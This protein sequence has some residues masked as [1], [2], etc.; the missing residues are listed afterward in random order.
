MKLSLL[1]MLGFSMVSIALAGCTLVEQNPVSEEQSIS[2]FKPNSTAIPFGKALRRKWGGAVVA[3]LDQDGW[4]DVITTHHGIHAQIYWNNQGKFSEPES[5]VKGDTHGLGVSD[6][7]G[8]GLI[9]IIVAQGGGDGS[10]PR[11]PLHFSVDRNRKVT[12]VGVF[13]YFTASRG[14]SIKYLDAD[15]DSV[16][17]LFV[18]GFAPRQVKELTTNQ[19][20][21]NN[22]GIGFYSPVTLAMPHDALSV[23]AI[24]TDV[25]ND[26]IT[27]IIVHGGRDL[28]LAKG[29]GDGSFTTATDEVFGELA[30]T[31]F[32]NG[33]SEIDYDNDGDFD[34]FLTRSRYQ[35]EAETYYDEKENNLA[36]FVFRDNF[37]F[38]ELDIG[39]DELVLENIQ[40]TYATY[41]IQ[42]GKS[43]TI[44]NAQRD[45]G[46]MGGSLTIN[47][48]EA[49]GWPDDEKVKRC[50]YWIFR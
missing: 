48:D 28:T 50:A 32:V 38:E 37:I 15:R 25:N 6:Y 40:E 2:L 49:I 3:D 8:D 7:D 24:T 5:F 23:K 4:E 20:Y 39:S 11:R 34:L 13:D 43:K 17:D 30:R 9:D 44:V 12:K 31:T 45:D 16:L 42:L 36:F 27:D 47:A 19:L 22:N 29:Q 41:D 10:G 33:V 1:S 21:R 26:R 46:H 18:T 14:R 35:F